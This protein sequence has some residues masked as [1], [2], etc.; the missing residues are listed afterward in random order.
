LK[1][2]A[3]GVWQVIPSAF[4]LPGLAVTYR[5]NCPPVPFELV[6]FMGII[7]KEIFG[8]VIND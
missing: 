3:G 5:N 7:T 4:G 8:G 1:L 6:W 2:P